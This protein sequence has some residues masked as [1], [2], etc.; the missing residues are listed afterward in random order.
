ML[1]ILT[2]GFMIGIAHAFEA[3]HVAAVSS[4]V[5]GRRNIR[6]IARH[7]AVWGLGH[8]IT[9]LVVGG[10]VLLL[11]AA[12]PPRIATELELLVGVMLVGLG[13]HVLYRLRRDRVHFHKHSHV[14]GQQH[15]H[16]HSHARETAPH[17]PS[18]HRHAHPD[19]SAL[20]TLMVGIMHGLAGSAALVLV[21]AASLQSPQIGIAYI[22]LFGLG[23]MLGMAAVSALIALPLKLTARYMTRANQGLQAAIGI[24]TIG[25]GAGTIHHTATALLN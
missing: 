20:R 13:L 2:L 21:A 3:D 23:S 7:G 17:Q 18:A 22:L 15:F 6:S 14:D 10:A 1:T 8:S 19:R 5:S 25:I 24:L 16:L 9:L 11:N 4:L 12:I